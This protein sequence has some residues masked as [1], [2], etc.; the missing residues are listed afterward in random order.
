MWSSVCGDES[1][2]SSHVLAFPV[3]VA[4]SLAG[5]TGAPRTMP[6]RALAGVCPCTVFAC[7]AVAVAVE[8]TLSV[9]SGAGAGG[10]PPT[11]FPV[12]YLRFSQPSVYV[13]LHAAGEMHELPS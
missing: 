3:N 12:V 7:D 10:P 11:S 4:H 8:L 2:S 1:V 6:S 5:N 9:G 13:P